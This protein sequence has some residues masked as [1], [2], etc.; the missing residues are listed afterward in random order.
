MLRFFQKILKVTFSISII[1]LICTN[2]I[3][4]ITQIPNQ[5]ELKYKYNSIKVD[6]SI[7]EIIEK[8]REIKSKVA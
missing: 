6:V 4:Y 2:S 1:I 3:I 8:N 7:K 5:E